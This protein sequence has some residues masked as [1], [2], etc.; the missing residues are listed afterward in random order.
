MEKVTSKKKNA[1]IKEVNYVI[2]KGSVSGRGNSL[3]KGPEAGACLEGLKN[4]KAPEKFKQ[5]E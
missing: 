2:S 4:S 3:C 1:G 5:R